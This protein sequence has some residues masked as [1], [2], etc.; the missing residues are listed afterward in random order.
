MLPTIYV[1]IFKIKFLR[2]SKNYWQPI[3]YS[4]QSRINYIPC[5]VNVNTFRLITIIGQY[6][7]NI[8]IAL[9]DSIPQTQQVSG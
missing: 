3:F 6:C 9:F 4:D 1:T 5:D 7:F 8:C 2:C